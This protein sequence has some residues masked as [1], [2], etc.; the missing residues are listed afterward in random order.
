MVVSITAFEAPGGYNVI[1]DSVTLRWTVRYLSMDN[2]EP[3]YEEMAKLV[4]GLETAYDVECTLDYVYDYPVLYNTEEKIDEIEE[5]LTASQGSYFE[6]VYRDKPQAASE[7]F[8]Y[9]LEKIPGAFIFVGAKPDG[10]DT[11]YPNHHP[12]FEVNEKSLL[13]SAKAM[14]EIVLNKLG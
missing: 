1:Q 9:Y 5:V 6:K 10:V 13:I 7:D 3:V 2:R 8:A 4:K 12:K 14:A 11:A